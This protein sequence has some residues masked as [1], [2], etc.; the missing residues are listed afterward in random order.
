[1]PVSNLGRYRL[2]ERVA[3][4]GMGEVYRGVEIGWGGVERP[5]AVKVIAPELA[6]HPDFI[7]TFIDEA[8]L[9]YRLVHANIVTV[10][11]ACFFNN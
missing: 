7:T 2:V 5:V 9:S 11:A 10:P 4:G 3:T 6:R 8:R 1:M